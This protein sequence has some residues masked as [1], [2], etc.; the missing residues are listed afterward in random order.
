MTEHGV[1]KIEHHL[2][3]YLSSAVRDPQGARNEKGALKENLQVL[4]EPFTEPFKEPLTE[5]LKE[6][7]RSRQKTLL[8]SA[9]PG[10]SSAERSPEASGSKGLL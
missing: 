5:P 6:P 7:M 3:S 1:A 8:A 4:R 10:L 2:A 9:G